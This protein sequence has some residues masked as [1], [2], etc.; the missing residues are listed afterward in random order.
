LDYFDKLTVSVNKADK[1]TVIIGQPSISSLLL[2]LYDTLVSKGGKVLYKP[3]PRELV[4][5]SENVEIFNEQDFNLNYSYIGGF[6][7]LLLELAESGC[8]EVIALKDYVPE[9]YDQ[10]LLDFGISLIKMDKLKNNIASSG[11]QNEL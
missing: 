10:V 2:E 4:K 7:T 1:L 9:Y 3:H 6:S 11:L 8:P 5:L